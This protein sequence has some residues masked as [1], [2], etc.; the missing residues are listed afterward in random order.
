MTLHRL[1]YLWQLVCLATDRIR[2]AGDVVQR[3]TH[4]KFLEL[5]AR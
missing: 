4:V 5:L 3:R 1:C 2:P